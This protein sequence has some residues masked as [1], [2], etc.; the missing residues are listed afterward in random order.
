MK[1]KLQKGFDITHRKVILP[2]EMNDTEARSEA[3]AVLG[4]SKSEAKAAAA[5]ENGKLGGRPRIKGNSHD[6][7]KAK[8]SGKRQ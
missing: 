3:A 4:R 6:R 8:R 7:R 2:I 5:R 1:I